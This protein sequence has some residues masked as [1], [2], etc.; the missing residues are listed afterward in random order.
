[1]I[2][3]ID[4]QPITEYTQSWQAMQQCIQNADNHQDQIW[5]LQHPAVYTQGVAGKPEH[6]LKPNDIP[7]VQSDRGG[8]ITYHGPGQIMVYTLLDLKRLGISIKQLVLQ[9]QKTVIDTMHH[10]NINAH[11]IETMPGVFV[12]NRKISSIGLRVKK[13]ICYHGIAIN[14]DMN[15]A[16]FAYINPCGYT[17][18]SVCQMR[19]FTPSIT[20]KEVKNQ[21]CRDFIQLFGY[22][23]TVLMSDQESSNDT[24]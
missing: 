3:Q 18:L 4:H 17:D 7:L 5:L 11:T 1:M 15:L 9:L 13:G 10:F 14:V 22:T 2:L 19:D 24:L 6:L 21:F 23:Q 16:P 12:E 20:L 8:Q